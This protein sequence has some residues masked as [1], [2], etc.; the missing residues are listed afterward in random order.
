MGALKARIGSTDSLINVNRGE[1]GHAVKRDSYAE[2][3]QVSA[4][5]T[6][7]PQSVMRFTQ[8]KNRI[9]HLLQ[10]RVYFVPSS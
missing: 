10:D 6:Y 3:D 9:Y 4:A 1:A 5:S 8:A 2:R 7:D